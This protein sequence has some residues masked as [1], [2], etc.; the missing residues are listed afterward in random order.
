MQLLAL[1]VTSQNLELGRYG[2]IDPVAIEDLLPVFA[3]LQYAHSETHT[4]VSCE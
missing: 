2:E 3:C 1:D 4:Q